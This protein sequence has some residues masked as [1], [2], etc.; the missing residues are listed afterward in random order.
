MTDGEETEPE[1]EMEDSE[2]HKSP[3]RR[4][5]KKFYYRKFCKPK[6]EKEEVLVSVD[7]SVFGPDDEPIRLFNY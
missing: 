6:E 7:S 4:K 5:H 1:T 3:R 2:E